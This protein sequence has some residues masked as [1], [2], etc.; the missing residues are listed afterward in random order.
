MCWFGANKNQVFP[1]SPSRF[2]GLFPDCRG[3]AI[4]SV[5]LDPSQSFRPGVYRLNQND[6]AFLESLLPKGQIIGV[7]DI[8]ASPRAAG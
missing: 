2:V 1:T 5:D 8:P 4:W 6:L 7:I 3:Q